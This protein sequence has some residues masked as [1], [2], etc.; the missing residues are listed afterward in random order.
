VG[1]IS[2]QGDG[3]VMCENCR[4]EVTRSSG[5]H[6]IKL[7]TPKQITPVN[8]EYRSLQVCNVMLT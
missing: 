6:A 8:Q 7:I 5:T 3:P 2:R 1:L 4:D